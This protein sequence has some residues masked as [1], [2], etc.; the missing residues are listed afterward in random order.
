MKKY[1]VIEKD[2]YTGLTIGAHVAP[3]GHIFTEIEWPYGEELLK[4]AVAQGRCKLYNPSKDKE[5]VKE[6]AKVND[7]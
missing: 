4:S 3:V 5:K 1:I 6:K 2:G 7:S